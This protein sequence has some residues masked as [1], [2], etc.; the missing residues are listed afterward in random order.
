MHPFPIK[1]LHDF[2]FKYFENFHKNFSFLILLWKK[3]NLWLL[4]NKLYHEF[5]ILIFFLYFID[6]F[7]IFNF[8]KSVARYTES[9]LEPIPI[10]LFLSNIDGGEVFPPPFMNLPLELR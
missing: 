3:N 7:F 5:F 6:N 9:K 8:C 10:G 1:F 4:K 2:E